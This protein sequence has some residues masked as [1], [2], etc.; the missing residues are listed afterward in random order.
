MC[1]ILLY[2]IGRLVNNISG[3]FKII[4]LFWTNL[5]YFFLFAGQTLDIILNTVLNKFSISFSEYYF[6][7]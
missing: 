4:L 7:F 5:R 6:L 1:I 3:E 2:I